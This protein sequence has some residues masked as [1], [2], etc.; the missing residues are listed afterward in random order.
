M[1]QEIIFSF[2]VDFRFPEEV[3]L[4]IRSQ[5]SAIA[6][7]TALSQTEIRLPTEDKFVR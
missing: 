7:Q 2:L 6:K 4:Q 5:A 1:I 3:P